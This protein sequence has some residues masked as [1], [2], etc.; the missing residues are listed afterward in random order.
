MA[1]QLD[2]LISLSR[3]TTVA[4]G[5]LP[6][7]RLV[8]EG[9]YHTF[10]TYDL[11]LVTVELFTGQLVLRDPKDVDRYRLLF[12]FFAKRAKWEDES[13]ARIAGIADEFR[14]VR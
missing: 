7:D 5:V 2:R 9:A 11:R 1:L 14:S 8:P 12:D 3:L 13:R 10:V 4:I 6:L